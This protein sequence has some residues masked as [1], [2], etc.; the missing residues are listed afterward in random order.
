MNKRERFQDWLSKGLILAD[1]AMG[2]M[3]H[4]HGVDL[5][6]C[7]DELNLTEPNH[8]LDL[9]KEYIEAGAQIIETNTYG[10]NG[11]KLANFGLQ[12]KVIE[13]NTAAVEISR[14]AIKSSSREV[15]IAGSVGPLGVSL[16]PCG[17]MQPDQALRIY[18][19]QISALE[20][21]GADLIFIETQ[22]DLKEAIQAVRAAQSVTELPV[23]ATMTFT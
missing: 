23:I 3:L 14:K 8:I 7:F 17:R 16:A 11:F 13:I 1:G 20:Q 12:D 5:K 19:D 10:A 15:L 18:E 21:A 4:N 9:H 6:T 22:T 2:T